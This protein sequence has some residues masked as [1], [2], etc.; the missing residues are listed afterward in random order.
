MT[1]RVVRLQDTLAVVVHTREDTDLPTRRRY[2]A[3]YDWRPNVRSFYDGL[4]DL[5]SSP[6]ANLILL[7]ADQ[8]SRTQ[9]ETTLI[10]QVQYNVVSA[11]STRFIGVASYGGTVG[12]H[13]SL[14]DF[15]LCRKIQA[16]SPFIA[17]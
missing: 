8:L 5:L 9:T 11:H 7:V 16:L 6:A 3:R 10:I 15:Q 1:R 17:C 4:E 12:G 13:V 2:S 14:V